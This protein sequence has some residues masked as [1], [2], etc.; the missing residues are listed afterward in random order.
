MDL[1]VSALEM[2]HSRIGE[3]GCVFPRTPNPDKIRK[4]QYENIETRLSVYA[5]RKSWLSEAHFEIFCAEI[6]NGVRLLVASYKK[7]EEVECGVA[8]IVLEK[9]TR[10]ECD[11][12]VLT[13]V[14]VRPIALRRKLFQVI[15]MNIFSEL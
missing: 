12:L 5:G 10:E 3:L 7:A 11:C 1:Y 4:L 8:E 9:Q 6:R 14:A 13:W 2:L 15:L